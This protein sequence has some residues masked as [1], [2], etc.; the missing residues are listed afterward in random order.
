M[1][2]W[3]MWFIVTAL[4]VIAWPAC[5]AACVWFVTSAAG[6]YARLAIAQF[7]DEQLVA[8]QTTASL[9]LKESKRAREEFARAKE[10]T[11]IEVQ[12]LKSAL[13]QRSI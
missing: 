9:A 11:E 10:A 4:G 6:E 2:V 3:L 12:Q 8:A 1:G 7:R 5:V 13:L